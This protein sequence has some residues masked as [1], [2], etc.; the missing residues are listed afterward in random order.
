VQPKVNR[1][2]TTTTSPASQ[3]LQRLE[4][5]EIT[6]DQYLDAR[7]D[8]A[9]APFA[10]KL[11]RDQLDFMRTTLRE[12]LELDPMLIELTRRATAGAIRP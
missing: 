3:L 1:D 7:V 12:Q 4:H 11:T 6:R 2:A 8:E 10:G 5:G 9:I